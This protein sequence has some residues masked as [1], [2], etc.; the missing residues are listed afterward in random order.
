MLTWILDYAVT[1][2]GIIGW[3]LQK[4]DNNAKQEPLSSYSP[5]LPVKSVKG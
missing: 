2:T 3:I 1:V 5:T 4:L